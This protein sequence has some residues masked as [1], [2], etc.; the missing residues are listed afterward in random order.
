MCMQFDC[1]KEVLVTFKVRFRSGVVRGIHAVWV[2]IK[3]T[4]VYCARCMQ[5]IIEA[6]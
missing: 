5:V 1:F 4:I 6:L 3:H 2:C